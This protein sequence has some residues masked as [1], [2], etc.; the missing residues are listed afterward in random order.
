MIRFW[1]TPVFGPWLN[2]PSPKFSDS[3]CPATLCALMMLM[4]G[5]KF[6][7]KVLIPASAGPN[8]C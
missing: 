3:L 7:P 2:A 8:G 5:K 4:P 6:D 1:K